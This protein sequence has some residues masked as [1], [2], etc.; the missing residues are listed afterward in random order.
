[1]EEE[2]RVRCF[3][4]PRCVPRLARALA[5]LPASPAP[6]RNRGWWCH[7]NGGV[8]FRD[9]GPLLPDG[10]LILP[11]RDVPADRSSRPLAPPDSEFAPGACPAC[12]TPRGRGGRAFRRL[13]SSLPLPR[14]IGWASRRRPSSVPPTGGGRPHAGRR[15]ASHAD[16][17][18]APACT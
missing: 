17:S 11:H 8:R 10:R 18:Q 15:G 14:G 7:C 3:L 12:R 1:M 4:L 16:D 6:T 13:P 2:G 9:T 5:K